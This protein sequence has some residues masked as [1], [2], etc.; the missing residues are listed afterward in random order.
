MGDQFHPLSVSSPIF[1]LRS[2]I[3]ESCTSQKDPKRATMV[4]ECQGN[5]KDVK[6]KQNGNLLQRIVR[7]TSCNLIGSDRVWQV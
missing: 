2:S 1:C 4:M 5:V 3:G 7:V 6:N